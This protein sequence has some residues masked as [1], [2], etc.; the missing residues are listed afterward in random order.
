M[1]YKFLYPQFIIF[2]LL[3]VCVNYSFGQTNTSPYSML[4]IGDIV[5]KNFDRSSGMGDAGIS[6]TSY[7]YIYDENPASI[8]YLSD[9]MLSMEVSGNFNAVSYKGE[10]LAKNVNSSQFQVQRFVMGTKI[11]PIWGLS[12]GLKQFSSSNYYFTQQQFIEGASGSYINT[13]HDGTGGINQVFLSNGVR[14]GKNLSLGA[15]VSY[16]FGHMKD[17]KDLLNNTIVG[18]QLNSTVNQYYTHFYFD[19]GLQYHVNVSPKWQLGLGAIGSLKTTLSGNTYYSLS[20]G[21]GSTSLPSQMVDDSIIGTGKF[22]LPV[23][24]GGGLSLTYDNKLTFAVDYKQE[25]WS[26]VHNSTSGFNYS[27]KNANQISG[28][29][30]YT[31][32]KN[33]FFR[34]QI[35]PFD[36]YFYQLGG[37]YNQ[38]YL[39]M[40]GQQIS[41]AGISLGVGFNSF[42]SGLGTMF[43]V[44]LGTRGTTKNNLIRGNYFQI[45]VTISYQSNW[46]KY[47]FQ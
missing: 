30:E 42:T 16:L 10:S 32:R 33:E 46:I 45:G 11:L 3:L 21:D 37:Y 28:G 7:R 14:L 2:L 5:S 19:G 38:E 24:Y 36:K 22:N 44:Q 39:V 13:T 31:K 23:T 9:R 18:T 41:N 27:F 20:Q 26:D 47:K 43:N 4:G 17:E 12:F 1:K 29:I 8:S 40:K 6:L 25:K 15:R 35:I 34:N